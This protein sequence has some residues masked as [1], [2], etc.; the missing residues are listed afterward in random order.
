[1]LA[2]VSR[3]AFAAVLLISGAGFPSAQAQD[4]A[5]S[6]QMGLDECTGIAFKKADARL[7]QLYRQI[8]ARLTEDVTTKARLVAAQRAWIS[9]RDAE[10][11]FRAAGVEGGSIYPMTVTMCRTDL[12]DQRVTALE[13]LLDCQEGDTSCPVP[14]AP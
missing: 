10:C 5:D 1:M 6:T 13:P 14:A 7:N 2:F 11:A 8:T 9:F 3:S 4:C 12:T